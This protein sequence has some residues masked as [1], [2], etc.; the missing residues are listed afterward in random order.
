M[1]PRVM[2]RYVFPLCAHLALN[3]YGGFVLLP[4]CSDGGVCLLGD[5]GNM[6]WGGCQ[7]RRVAVWV[8][9][10]VGAVLRRFC[11]GL[12]LGAWGLVYGGAARW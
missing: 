11:V 2:L 9:C 10:R 7:T 1:L 3:A 8:S 12:V 4:V 5:D 6:R